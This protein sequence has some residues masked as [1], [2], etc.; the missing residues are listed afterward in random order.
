MINKCKHCGKKFSYKGT[1]CRTCISRI[2]R[3]NNKRKAVEYRGGKC[4]KCGYNG[5]L[6]ALE[7]HHLGEKDLTIAKAMN[8][9]WE[10]IKEELD[11]C[12]LLCSNCHRIEHSNYDTIDE[13]RSL[14]G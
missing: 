6:A 11:K 13:L 2:R 12:M 9:R 4:E 8:R 5:H 14:G 7:F 1:R 3:Y 10:Y